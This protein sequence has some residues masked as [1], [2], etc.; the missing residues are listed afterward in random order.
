MKKSLKYE[1]I[2]NVS[3]WIKTRSNSADINRLRSHTGKYLILKTLTVIILEE[4]YIKEL[5]IV[6]AVLLHTKTNT[7]L[8]VKFLLGSLF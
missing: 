1:T 3:V 7:I 5:R 4:L 2:H 8:L 6:C